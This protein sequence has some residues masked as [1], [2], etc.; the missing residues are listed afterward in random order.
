MWK[1]AAAVAVIVLIAPSLRS[2]VGRKSVFCTV[3]A[4]AGC[5]ARRP[6]WCSGSGPAWATSGPGSSSNRDHM[7]ITHL[8]RIRNEVF[9]AYFDL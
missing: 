9:T 1:K 5:T 2:G 8:G 6:R 3:G 7:I 4:T